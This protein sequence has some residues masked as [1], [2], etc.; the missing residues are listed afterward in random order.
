M[1]TALLSAMSA[2]LGS[3]VGG[4]ASITSAWFS[5]NAQ[6]RRESVRAE[7]RKRESLYAQFIAECSNLAIDALTHSSLEQPELLVKIYAL[8][9]RIRLTSSD[10][11]V[12][13]A[14]EAIRH[15][16]KLYLAPNITREQLQEL[17]LNIRDDPLKIFSETCRAEFRRLADAR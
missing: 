15:I 6:G 12:E 9:N 11:V 14:G 10:A 5:Q 1:D 16:M 3:A 8:H 4:A 7:I 17:A 13:A 2:V